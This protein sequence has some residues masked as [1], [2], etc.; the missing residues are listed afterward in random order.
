[1]R[2]YDVNG[3]R[4]LGKTFCYN[5]YSRVHF[6]ILFLLFR[7]LVQCGLAQNMNGFDSESEEED[8][9]DCSFSPS[10]STWIELPDSYEANHSSE[11]LNRRR[12]S[13]KTYYIRIRRQSA[14][15]PLKGPLQPA[16][17]SK[18]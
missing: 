3:E 16:R 17:H 5:C 7:N 9:L 1:M 4:G 13:K 10:A 6:F 11:K 2:V 18:P 12:C 14:N 8:A 15:G